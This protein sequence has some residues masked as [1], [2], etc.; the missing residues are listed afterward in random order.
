MPPIDLPTLT[1]AAGRAFFWEFLTKHRELDKSDAKLHGEELAFLGFC[2][3]RFAQSHAQLMQDLFV[4]YRT[5][6]RRGGYFVEFGATDGVDLSNTVLLEREYG[7]TGILAEPFAVWHADLA[8]NR[9]AVIDHRCVWT[10]SGEKMAFIASREPELAGLSICADEDMHVARRMAG[11]A[12]AQVETVSLID[13]LDQH[14]APNDIDY[15]SVDTEGSE[16][17]ILSAFDFSRYRIRIV[18]V[19]HNYVDT[20]REAIRQVLEAN[21]YRREFELYSGWDDWYVRPD[22]F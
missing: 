21:G 9:R 7:W 13:L 6:S 17:D 11:A 5:G 2:V 22:L 3:E 1:T 14:A 19:E 12:E 4:L 20:K 16:F 15:M 18:S 8:A 10:A